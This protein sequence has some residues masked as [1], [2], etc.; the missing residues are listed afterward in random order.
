[1]SPELS[2]SHNEVEDNIYNS[3]VEITYGIL[4]TNAEALPITG[5]SLVEKIVDS[6]DMIEIAQALEEKYGAIIPKEELVKI[7][8]VDDIVDKV[9][10]HATV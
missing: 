2:N 7:K 5:D 10:E 9:R 6:L 1:M 4:D 3:V 8:T